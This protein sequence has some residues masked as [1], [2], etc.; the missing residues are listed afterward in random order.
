MWRRNSAITCINHNW[1]DR[2]P[3]SSCVKAILYEFGALLLRWSS[4][5][6]YFITDVWLLSW[7][8]AYCAWCARVCDPVWESHRCSLQTLNLARRG[9]FAWNV[10]KIATKRLDWTIK[11][12]LTGARH[13]CKLRTHSIHV[14]KCMTRIRDHLLV[15]P[16]AL[17]WF[18]LS[19]QLELL[20]C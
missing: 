13:N 8:L 1:F 11:S 5:F 18:S 6:N 3:L 15:I 4:F 12:P 20:P 10:E 14:V 2:I 17:D 7:N 16:K 19:M 9:E